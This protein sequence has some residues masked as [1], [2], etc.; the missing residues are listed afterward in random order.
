[1]IDAASEL[2]FTLVGDADSG[3]IASL[4]LFS[5]EARS[6]GEAEG[7]IGVFSSDWSTTSVGELGEE[8]DAGS[9]PFGCSGYIA[10]GGGLRTPGRG[11]KGANGGERKFTTGGDNTRSKTVLKDPGMMDD[12]VG[13]MNL[14]VQ[15]SS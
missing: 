10:Q 9:C 12:G 3:D 6:V 2:T 1:M 15:T 11:A 14:F 8:C 7:G 13:L 4:G 5:A